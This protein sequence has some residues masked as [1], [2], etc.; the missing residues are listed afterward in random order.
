MHRITRSFACA[1]RGVART[2]AS[3]PNFRIHLAA[4]LLVTALGLV[5][6]VNGAHA[7]LLALAVGLV[8]ATEA[9][10]TA[11]E[12]LADAVHPHSHPGIARA[13]DAAAGAVL[14]SA[15]VAVLVGIWVLGPIVWSRLVE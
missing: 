3:Q 15:A 12:E 6:G 2:A 8:L 14:V 5:L 11:L 10:N 4:A 13:K 7:A 9:F 1:S